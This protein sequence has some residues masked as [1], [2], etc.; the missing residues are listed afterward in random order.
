MREGKSSKKIA[1]LLNLSRHRVE[2]D[3]ARVV[4]GLNLRGI[5]ELTLRAARKGIIS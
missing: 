5:P 1:N 4:Q 2:T 3:R